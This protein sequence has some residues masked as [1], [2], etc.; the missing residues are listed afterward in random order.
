L[1]KKEFFAVQVYNLI[2]FPGNKYNPYG[3]VA[4]ISKAGMR[5]EEGG[6]SRFE[7]G[8]RNKR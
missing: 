5:R 7:E 6:K 1:P 3:H 8:M 2:V 4:I